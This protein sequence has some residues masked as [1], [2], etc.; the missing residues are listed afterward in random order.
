MTSAAVPSPFW[1]APMELTGGGGIGRPGGGG[2]GSPGGGVIG[3]LIA[4]VLPK[5][6]PYGASMADGAHEAM[7]ALT[8]RD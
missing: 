5:G 3:S 2:V 7:V 1:G 6:L 4:V 8:G